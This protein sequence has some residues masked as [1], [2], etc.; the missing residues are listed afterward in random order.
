MREFKFQNADVV[1]VQNKGC[2]IVVNKG[3]A[4]SYLYSI[5]KPRGVS[6]HFM[7]VPNHYIGKCTEG[8]AR[9]WKKYSD[10]LVHLVLK[11]TPVIDEETLETLVDMFGPYKRLYSKQ[12]EIAT[13]EQTLFFLNLMGSKQYVESRLFQFPKQYEEISFV[14]KSNQK[15]VNKK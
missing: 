2:A 8:V 5:R 14:Y 7:V 12:K 3:E 10:A 11:V 6:T 15:G 1:S 4:F 9:E 13:F